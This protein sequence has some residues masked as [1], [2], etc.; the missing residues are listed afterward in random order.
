[1]NTSVRLVQIGLCVAKEPDGADLHA[2]FQ[3]MIETHTSVDT[4]DSS[5][6]IFQTDGLELLQLSH[7]RAFT[8]ASWRV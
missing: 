3:T 8:I 7:S 1:M 5:K 4:V 6:W 2:A